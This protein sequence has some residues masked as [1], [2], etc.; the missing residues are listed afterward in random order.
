[1]KNSTLTLFIEIDNYNLTFF[2]CESD[3]QNYFKI[4]FKS[5]I[6]LDGNKNIVISD[7]NEIFSV[8]KKNIYAIEQKLNFTFKE[9]VLILENFNPSF[10]NLTGFKKL[11]GSQ[12]L[13]EN[14]TYILNS[15]K[16]CV[17]EIENNKKVLH[18][19]NSNFN[20]DGKKIENLPIGLFGDFYSHELSFVLINLNDYKNLINIFEK[21]NLSIKKILIKS[22]VSGAHISDNNINADT[23]FQI[24]INSTNSK[25]IYF[26]N[27]SLKF[28]QD[29]NFGSEI[30]LKDISK[31]TLLKTDKIKEILNEIKFKENYLDE[32]IIEKKFFDKDNY[33]K[34]KK[35]LIFDIAIARVEEI[36][37]LIIFRNKNLKYYSELSKKLFLQISENIENNYLKDIFK[38]VLSKNG[39]L[40]IKFL[41]YYMV[42]GMMKTANKLVHFGWKKEAIPIA[43]SKKTIIARIFDTIFG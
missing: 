4:I 22:F 20:L 38:T 17:E 18:I 24:K 11:N 7:F 25:V 33:R 12:V 15:L 1:M 14:I 2:V 40:E 37:D 31:I 5:E 35:K 43:Q 32:E 3:I 30:I 27:N 39:K 10:V 19:F 28:E 23:F 16:S 42:E 36:F 21:C 6:Q 34:I 29:F 13:K 41:E 26:E 8:I 9:V